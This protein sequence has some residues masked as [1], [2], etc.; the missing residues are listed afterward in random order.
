MLTPTQNDWT[1][2]EAAHLLNRAGFGGSP[3]QTRA[4]HSLGRKKAVGQLLNPPSG[5]FQLDPPEWVGGKGDETYKEFQ[6][7][8]KDLRRQR[9]GMSAGEYDKARR[10]LRRQMQRTRRQAG[11][12]LQQWWFDNMMKTSTPLQEKMTLFWHDHFP[13]SLQKVRDPRQLYRQN[14]LFREY[15]TGNFKGLT[16]RIALDPAMMHYLD[17]PQSRKGKPNEN[18][19]RELLELFTLGEGNYTEQDI[20][21]AARAFTGYT[22]NRKTGEAIHVEKHWDEGEKTFMG[23]TGPF[24]GEGIVNIVFE[25]DACARYLP[26]K[27]WEFFVYDNPD[28][29]TVDALANTFSNGKF[30]VAPVLQEIFLSEEFYSPQSIRTRIKSPVEFLVQMLRQLEVKES[31]P[32]RYLTRVQGQLGQQ[33]LMPPNVAG[34]DWGKAWINTNSLLTRYNV[35]GMVTKGSG[36]MRPEMDRKLGMTAQKMKGKQSRKRG[37]GR[38]YWKGPDYKDIAPPELRQDPGRLVQA[39]TERLFQDELKPLQREKFELYAQ[40]KRTDGFTDKEVAEL[41]HLMM[42]TPYYQ[43]T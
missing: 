15:A 2:A 34:W 30:E 5:A 42:S 32:T 17:T 18:F 14:Q 21:E 40:A 37:K 26:K 3:Q 19:A 23:R 1:T 6:K 13:S 11:G 8:L 10:K 25:Q 7:Q 20:K 36:G 38:N 24:N 16:Q 33:L 9:D 39:L 29:E 4:F 12:E 41:I 28:R 35:A 43:L 27:L 22:I 31:V